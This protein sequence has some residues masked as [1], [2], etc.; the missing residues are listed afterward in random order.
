MESINNN[1]L[2]ANL[3]SVCPKDTLLDVKFLT[4][5]WQ[6]S[7]KNKAHGIKALSKID[8]EFHWNFLVKP[9]SQWL[10]LR[11]LANTT[12]HL[13]P[14]LNNAL[15]TSGMCI[16]PQHPPKLKWMTYICEL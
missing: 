16:I 15:F 8:L 4:R 12:S 14:T 5:T 10:V 13:L 7:S 9:H 6:E 1:L 11:C 3:S 2:Q